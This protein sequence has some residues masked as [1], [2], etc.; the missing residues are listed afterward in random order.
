MYHS[1]DFFKNYALRLSLLS[2]SV[3]F[4]AVS[5]YFYFDASSQLQTIENE[6][7]YI[8]QKSIDSSM[9][10]E[11]LKNELPKHID[12][13]SRGYIGDS[14][15]LEWLELISKLVVDYSL[16]EVQFSVENSRIEEAEEFIYFDE[17]IQT[18]SSPMKLNFVFM[19]EIDFVKFFEGLKNNA[20]G[21]ADIRDCDMSR[22][23]HSDFNEVR[24]FRG[25]CYIH[26]YRVRNMLSH[27][28]FVE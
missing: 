10:F 20:H 8:E 23:E 2:A 16:P 5:L 17:N 14:K 26:W 25:H 4:L 6:F 15:R 7:S 13:L 1:K 18:Y 24:L 11:S 12:S 9:A 21:V 27:W 28:G 22:I 19:H 3:L